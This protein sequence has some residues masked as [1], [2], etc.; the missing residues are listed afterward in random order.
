MTIEDEVKAFMARHREPV[1]YASITG[2]DTESPGDPER[3]RMV[4]MAEE[5]VPSLGGFYVVID[6][7]GF[8]G[9]V[10]RS[11]L[12]GM[13]LLTS[14]LR[15]KIKIV[16]SLDEVLQTEG[17]AGLGVDPLTARASLQ[18]DGLLWS[19]VASDR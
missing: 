1:T 13:L 18:R 4:A 7:V 14:R 12:A 8:L 5:L 9:S 17:A 11:T 10:Q 2:K 16:S 15:G 6:S 3:R 19:D